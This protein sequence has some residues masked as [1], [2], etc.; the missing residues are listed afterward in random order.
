LF[1]N[2]Q[3]WNFIMFKKLKVVAAAALLAVSGLSNAAIDNGA[4]GNGSLFF[5]AWDGARSYTRDLGLRIDSFEAALAA[6]G[7]LNFSLASD[8]L[9]TSYLTTANL[10]SLAWNIVAADSN[11]A[12]RNIA[13]YTTLPGTRIQADVNR[14]VAGAIA[15]FANSVNNATGTGLVATGG[16]SATANIGAPAYAGAF[17][18]GSTLANFLNFSSA[19]ST[20]NNT[21]ATGLNLLRI[22]G[23]ATGIA[24]TTYTPYADEGFAAR[25]YL[26]GGNLTISAV[27]EPETYAMLLAGLGLMGAIARRRRKAASQK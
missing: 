15:G 7:G 26:N 9:F 14:N 11:G 4:G 23:G 2:L 5:S 20:A 25:A 6:P 21:Y 27:P 17:A 8:A 1:I 19:G 18:F 16:N 12:R 24:A 22:N 13:T 3:D 10:G